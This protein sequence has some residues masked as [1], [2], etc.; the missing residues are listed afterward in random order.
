M[1]VSVY[2]NRMASKYRTKIDDITPGVGSYNI[3]LKK[4]HKFAFVNSK[5]NDKLNDN[6]GPLSY[7]PQYSKILKK[8]PMFSI[9]RKYQFK[10]NLNIPGPADYNNSINFTSV[11]HS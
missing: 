3:D 9:S 1:E 5:K 7:D 10:D 11:K 4:V 8:T 6:P 2:L